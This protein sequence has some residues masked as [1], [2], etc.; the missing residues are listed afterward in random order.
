MANRLKVHLKRDTTSKNPNLYTAEI[1][2][3]ATIDFHQIIQEL[4]EGGLIEADVK[5]AIEIMTQFNKKTA[6]LITSGHSVDTGLVKLSPEIKGILF[7]QTWNPQINKIDVSVKKGTELKSAIKNTI[8]E[9]NSVEIAELT[10]QKD[11]VRKEEEKTSLNQ[12]YLK[13]ENDDPACG[14]A[15]RKWLSK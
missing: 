13:F 3:E 5:L 4:V 6:E 15:F 8:I 12:D 2:N 9:V 14:I 11:E 10:N 1:L 7:A